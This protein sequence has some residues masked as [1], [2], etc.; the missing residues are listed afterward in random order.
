MWLIDELPTNVVQ[1][2]RSNNQAD[3]ADKGHDECESVRKAL[4]VVV[5]HHFNSN[6][7]CE[8]QLDAAFDEKAYHNDRYISLF[9]DSA[10]E[11]IL[12]H[13]PCNAHTQKLQKKNRH[14]RNRDEKYRAKKDNEILGIVPGIEEG[15]INRLIFSF[16]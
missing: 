6:Q 8:T 7:R 16:E 3:N 13:R 15:L 1:V 5:A 11:A 4:K 12:Y 9:P 14:P 2:K 10:G